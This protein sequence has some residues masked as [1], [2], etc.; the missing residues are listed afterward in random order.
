[1]T[2]QNDALVAE[3][4]GATWRKVWFDSVEHL[5]LEFPNTDNSYDMGV[6]LDDDHYRVM[7]G[8][9]PFISNPT[10]ETDGI[11]LE[12]VQGQDDIVTRE[13]GGKLKEIVR[14]NPDYKDTTVHPLDETVM[15]Y[16]PGDYARAL[17]ATRGE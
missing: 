5:S 13:F 3:M 14:E 16:K 1:M 8:I 4:V 9:H 7:R 15:N 17:L 12:W 6:F 11:V 10:F 2:N